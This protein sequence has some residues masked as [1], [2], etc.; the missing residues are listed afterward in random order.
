[1]TLQ[2]VSIMQVTR[3][4]SWVL[5]LPLEPTKQ[6]RGHVQAGTLGSA[7]RRAWLQFWKG[8][9]TVPNMAGAVM[10]VEEA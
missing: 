4:W 9:E 7:K 3:M 6:F 2:F 5:T 1:M 8:Q 10:Q